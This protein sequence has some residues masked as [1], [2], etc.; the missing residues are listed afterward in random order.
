MRKMA[1]SLQ[2]QAANLPRR[3]IPPPTKAFRSRRGELARK[4]KHKKRGED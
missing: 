2:Q 3:P 1:S 4:A